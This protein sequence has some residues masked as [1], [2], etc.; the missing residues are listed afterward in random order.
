[1]PT[2]SGRG[3]TG[4]AWGLQHAPEPGQP[5]DLALRFAWNHWRGRRSPQ[6]TLV[7]WKP[8]D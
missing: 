8:A 4:I 6:I 2:G 5:I 3:I 1:M 7:D